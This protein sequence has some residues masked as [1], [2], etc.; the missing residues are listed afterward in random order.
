MEATWSREK[1][2]FS[3]LGAVGAVLIAGTQVSAAQGV[4]NLASWARLV[5]LTWVAAHLP[6]LADK[7]GLAIGIVFLVT[8]IGAWALHR[9]RA[10][11]IKPFPAFQNPIV[12]SG[13]KLSAHAAIVPIGSHGLKT[14]TATGDGTVLG[15]S[16]GTVVS[17]LVR[18]D[19]TRLREILLGGRWMLNFNPARPTGKKEISFAPDGR[20]AVGA[21]SNESRWE[22]LD[23]ILRITRATGELQNDFRFDEDRGQFVCTNNSFAKGLKDQTIFRIGGTP[24]D[25]IP[26][27][28]AAEQAYAAL[29]GTTF[30]DEIDGAVGF[31]AGFSGTKRTTEE[32]LRLVMLNMSRHGNVTGL[33]W[34]SRKRQ[35]VTDMREFRIYPEENCLRYD[36]GDRP[37]FAELATTQAAI[38]EFVRFWKPIAIQEAAQIAFERAERERRLEV[39]VGDSS[40][41]EDRL[42]SFKYMMLVEATKGVVILNGVKQPSRQSMPIP[43]KQLR[44]LYPGKGE[45]TLRTTTPDKVAFE[46]VTISGADLETVIETYRAHA[47]AAPE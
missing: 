37:I 10:S 42:T 31:V 30:T 32:I 21:N 44:D 5:G 2:L 17:P 40:D 3:A 22:F 9:R 43:K 25:L 39:V 34:P 26:L 1:W 36:D 38:D 19:T 46:R 41:P 18:P 14:K 11:M 24:N 13:G 47:K 8:P 45:S 4:S 28:K 27:N 35:P 12:E 29:E 15:R 7:W 33:K 23:E 6:P 20:I 16:V